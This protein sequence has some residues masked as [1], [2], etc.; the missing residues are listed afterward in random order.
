MNLTNSFLARVSRTKI[1]G[2]GGLLRHLAL[3]NH[4]LKKF[5]NLKN[6]RHLLPKPVKKERGM[7]K[8]NPFI[9]KL[10]VLLKY[11]DKIFTYEPREKLSSGDTWKTFIKP[12]I[13]K[14]REARNLSCHFDESLMSLGKRLVTHRD[15]ATLEHLLLMEMHHGKCKFLLI[16]FTSF[17]LFN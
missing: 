5:F 7:K 15:F 3:V 11:P 9:S 4:R 6:I 2:Y 13:R 1:D 17:L 10:N 12:I 8:Q 14:V 16:Y